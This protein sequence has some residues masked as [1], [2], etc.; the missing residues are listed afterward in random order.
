M[1]E[2]GDTAHE[3]ANE[4]SIAG[5]AIQLAV[6]SW[7]LELGALTF[8]A[9]WLGHLR[10][11]HPASSLLGAAMTLATFLSVAGL[12]AIA[13]RIWPEK[14]RPAMVLTVLLSLLFMHLTFEFSGRLGRMPAAL[15]AIGLGVAGTR[16][17]QKAP[18]VTKAFRRAWIPLAI[19]VAVWSAAPLT[20][21]WARER[22]S[23]AQLPAADTR[24]PNVLLIILDTVRAISMGL[25]DDNGVPTTNLDRFA[26]RG[27]VFRRAIAPAPW[28]LPSHASM[29]TGR[30]VCELVTDWGIPFTDPDS[31]LAEVLSARGY[32]TGGF[33]ANLHYG[34]RP[35]G[36]A[37]GFAHYEDFPFTAGQA[38]LS[39]SLGRATTNAPLFRRITGYRELLNR[40]DAARVT[41]DFL[42]WADDVRGDHP[43]RP[44]FAFL[45][46]FDGHEPYLAPEPYH[47]RYAQPGPDYTFRYT[48]NR[49]E[50]H[51]MSGLT[52]EEIAP[53]LGA[54]NGA[55]ASLD[56]QLGNLFRELE[57]RQ[58]LDNT[59]VIVTSDHG[60]EFGENGIMGHSQSIYMTLLHVPLVMVWPTRIVAR[61]VVDQ[62]VGLR[63]LPATLM[64]LLGMGGSSP[65]PGNSWSGH[66]SGT[67]AT[68][69]SRVLLSANSSAGRRRSIVRGRFHYLIER[70][71]DEQTEK[72]YDILADPL[73]QIDLARDT[74]H[75]AILDSLRSDMAAF[76]A[77]AC[78]Q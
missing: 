29:F 18:V 26:Q 61:T 56:A 51:R 55:I 44:F 73:S 74:L 58:L 40:K 24:A 5:L 3:Q 4:A 38:I 35:Y 2:S 69:D 22:R 49:A 72:L 12:L 23:L 71:G 13:R 37:R 45:N 53:Q 1:H 52:P 15:L 27:A 62:P 65:I 33:V 39:T 31:T 47:S 9:N 67:A 41:G 70:I 43:D 54:Y 32:V 36:L 64:D 28:T 17:G 60:E 76:S 42:D 11:L 50:R 7:L 19:I 34:S 10:L 63:D 14:V 25:F 21:E 77:A 59:I 6:V 46:L 20:R 16:L 75:A 78:G 30:H 68:P 66:L 57:T 8:K 48:T